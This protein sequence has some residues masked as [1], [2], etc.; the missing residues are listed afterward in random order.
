[1]INFSTMEAWDDIDE[2]PKKPLEDI[3]EEEP[4]SLEVFV[5]DKGY[6]GSEWSLSPIQAD[7]VTYMERIYLPSLFPQMA[8]AFGGYWKQTKDVPMKN[9]ISAEWAKGCVSGDTEVYDPRSGYWNRV[10]EA[11]LGN[12]VS[13]TYQ[14]DEYGN[15]NH[16]HGQPYNQKKDA[17][18]I[19]EAGVPF[20]RGHGKMLRVTTRTGLS[21][22]VYEGHLFAGKKGVNSDATWTAAG[23]LRGGNLIAVPSYVPIMHPAQLGSSA[24]QWAKEDALGWNGKPGKFN[25]I[26]YTATLGQIDEFLQHIGKQKVTHEVAVGMKRLYLRKGVMATIR[27]VKGGWKVRPASLQSDSE[28]YWDMVDTVEDIG[29]ADYWDM[30]VPDMGTYIANGIL[31]S[32]S[33]KDHTVRIGALRVAYLLL[34]LKS[35]QKYFGMPEQDSIHMLNVAANAPQAHRAF[36]APMARAVK[37]GWFADKADPKRDTIMFD[38]NIEAV[39]GHSDAEA[40]EGLN[41]I[42]GVTDEIDAFKTKSELIGHG[43]KAREASTTAESILNMIESSASTRFPAN[44]KRVAIS[45]PRYKGSTIQ[46]LTKEGKEDMAAHPKDSVYYASGPFPTWEVNPL[47]KRSDFDAKYRADPAEAAAKY[48]C[49][50]FRSSAPYFRNP[51]NFQTSVDSEQ[52]PLSLDYEILHRTSNITGKPVASW[53]PKYH[54]DPGLQPRQGARYAIHADLAIK[55]DRAGVAMSHIERWET[56]KVVR[57]DDNG[58]A[59][60]HEEIRPVVRNDF[61]IY[62][63]ADIGAEPAREIQIRWVRELVTTLIARGF[64]ICQ[65]TYDGFQSVDS[66]QLLTYQGIETQRVSTDRDPS[67]W[68]SLKD[69]ASEGRLR[70][71]YDQLLIDE[72]EGLSE[73]N[74]KVDHPPAGSKDLADAF[75]CSIVGALVVG[76]EESSERSIVL[77]EATI[78]D[79]GDYPDLPFGMTHNGFQ[80]PIGLGGYG[81]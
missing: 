25:K 77:S 11:P 2:S 66:M 31:N 47:R 9:L 17:I 15:T 8:D 67:I 4:V 54:F 79:V 30:N 33:G 50:P 34:C 5:K 13:G 65:V 55:G 72:L 59:T 24:M 38:K 16:E 58:T 6:L 61:T 75:A 68:K 49:K 7:L 56:H 22:D 3:F 12:F 70:M 46:R 64:F 42:L 60:V 62:Y 36:F 32:N 71:P 81:A 57:T 37:H 80:M 74:G 52:Q 29:E 76:G 10:D 53:E 35:P 23:A 51:E 78:F 39:S 21:I 19:R 18:L 45:Y 44:F 26:L 27:E 28:I 40:Q 20:V 69:I 41:I 1:M 73:V 43:N 63:E 14:V 48:E